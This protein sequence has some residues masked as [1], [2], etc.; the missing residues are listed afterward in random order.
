VTTISELQED[1]T[2]ELA[3]DAGVSVT[4]A[5]AQE[6]EGVLSGTPGAQHELDKLSGTDVSQ[7]EH[8]V[9]EAFVSA[10]GTPLKIS[11]ALVAVGIL[12]AVVLLRR[13]EP[14]DAE[15]VDELTPS[16]TPRPA[17]L[18]GADEPAPA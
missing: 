18:R 1:R 3:G 5:Q 16:V 2:V 17:P 14:A 10:L 7:V 9:R 6:L 8:A 4:D 13:S 12:L 15:P 11:P